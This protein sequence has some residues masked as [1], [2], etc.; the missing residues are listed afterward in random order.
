MSTEKLAKEHWE[1][2]AYISR[3]VSANWLNYWKGD[4]LH[5]V[6]NLCS[7]KIGWEPIMK[8]RPH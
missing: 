8:E 2:A 3:S 6:W 5:D 7:G 4:C 1:K